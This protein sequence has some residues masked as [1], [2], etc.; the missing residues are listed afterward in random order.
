MDYVK[1]FAR[2]P[3]GYAK[4]VGDTEMEVAF[5]RFAKAEMNEEN[6]ELLAALAVWSGKA[7]TVQKKLAPRLPREDDKIA[8]FLAQRFLS[9]DAPKQVNTTTTKVKEAL[10][11]QPSPSAFDDIAQDAKNNLFDPYSRFVTHIRGKAAEAKRKVLEALRIHQKKKFDGFVLGGGKH[12]SGRYI[13]FKADDAL[14]LVSSAQG[15]AIDTKYVE[16]AKDL[17]CVQAGNGIWVQEGKG[18]NRVFTISNTGDVEEFQ[19]ALTAMGV[20]G[21]VVGSN[22]E[23]V[24]EKIAVIDPKKSELVQKSKE[25][26]KQLKPKSKKVTIKPTILASRPAEG[27]DT[28]DGAWKSATT[29]MA[30]LMDKSLVTRAASIYQGSKE[31]DKL[32]KIVTKGNFWVV[33]YA[34]PTQ[35][36]EHADA[37]Y[38]LYLYRGD[39][40]PVPS[41]KP[42]SN[43][44]KTGWVPLV[45]Q[46][47][48]LKDLLAQNG[49]M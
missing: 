48:L 43:A 2:M 31:P 9:P 1:L 4:M 42:P 25:I 20:K 17:G 13:V 29:L 16:A 35:L 8:E 23:G 10:S 15:K 27:E 30:R 34:D 37:F 45:T 19:A 24:N 11:Q 39:K 12:P 26:D 14:V 38:G 44:I 33:L 40:K 18:D 32:E 49:M 46:G 28:A 7:S 47:H 41:S 6:I 3:S 36:G 21:K 22:T 5:W